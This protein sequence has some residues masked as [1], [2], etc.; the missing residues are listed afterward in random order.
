MCTSEVE[1]IIYGADTTR[2]E[3]LTDIVN[4]QES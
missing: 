2:Y 3:I 4:N 1:N